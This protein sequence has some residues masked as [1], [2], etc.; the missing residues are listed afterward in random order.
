MR[1]AW[2]YLGLH[3]P[4]WPYST[5]APAKFQRPLIHNAVFAYEQICITPVAA[6][7][8][9]SSPFHTGKHGYTPLRL[10]CGCFFQSKACSPI[11]YSASA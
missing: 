1:M 9:F 6:G 5:R 2:Y 7:E 3:N 4:Q 11:P 8:T 10:G